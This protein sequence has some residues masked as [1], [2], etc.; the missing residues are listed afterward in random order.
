LNFNLK[1]LIHLRVRAKFNNASEAIISLGYKEIGIHE[2]GEKRLNSFKNIETGKIVV[3]RSMINEGKFISEV[4][5]S[6][7]NINGQK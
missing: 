1:K 5:V 6:P 2:Q 7:E 4:T 3:Y